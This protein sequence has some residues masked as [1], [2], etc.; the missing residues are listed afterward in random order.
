MDSAFTQTS[1]IVRVGKEYSTHS[2]HN[3]KNHLRCTAMSQAQFSHSFHVYSD[4]DC[5]FQFRFKKADLPVDAKALAIFSS[6]YNISR[7]RYRTDGV[8]CPYIVPKRFRS[9]CVW[10]NLEFHFGKHT[11]QLSDIIWETVEEVIINKV[12]LLTVGMSS[13]IIN[14]R[15][16]NYADAVCGLSGGSAN[17]VDFISGTVLGIARPSDNHM[18]QLVVYNGHNKRHGINFQIISAS[19][20]LLLHCFGL[21]EGRRHDWILY[22]RSNMDE[23]IE[24]TLETGGSRYGIYRDSGYNRS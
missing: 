10:K 23:L 20:G 9:N 22:T 15:A 13:G 11:S 6:V 5:L 14:A 21:I 24:G 2:F 7:S 16:A 3:R 18:A 8:L 1:T 19:A 4:S 17:K 12:S